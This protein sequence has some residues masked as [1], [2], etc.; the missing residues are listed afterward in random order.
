MTAL[1][2]LDTATAQ[3]A[4]RKAI[5]N[6]AYTVVNSSAYNGV[7]PGS[8]AYY[9]MSPWRIGLYAFDVVAA[10]LVAA[11]ICWIVLRGQDEKKHPEKYEK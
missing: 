4:V 11:G 7:A 5:K 6:I 3:W 10:I 8:Y 2:D 1:N 9:D